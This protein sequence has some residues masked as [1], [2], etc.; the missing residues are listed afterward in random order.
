M[1]ARTG[2]IALVSSKLVL[3]RLVVS[4][5]SSGSLTSAVA[6]AGIIK[7]STIQIVFIALEI[8]IMGIINLSSC[9]K[10]AAF[11]L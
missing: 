6:R 2:Y 4:D 5:N 9:S 1:I 8:E 10:S 3:K 11:Y 7:T